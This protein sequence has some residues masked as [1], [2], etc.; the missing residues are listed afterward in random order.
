MLLVLAREQEADQ[1]RAEQDR[2]HAGHVGPLVPVQERG[3]GAGGDG[4]GVLRVLLREVSA[5]ENDLVSSVC[6]VSLIVL[7][8]GAAAMLAAIA[9][10]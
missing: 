10:A 4:I 1:R 6:V 3:L 8:L 9:D 2:D 7:A 5:L